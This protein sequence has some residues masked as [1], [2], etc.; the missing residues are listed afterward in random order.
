MLGYR[1]LGHRRIEIK[2]TA[3]GT[4]L[5]LGLG[6]CIAIVLLVRAAA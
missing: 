1:R 6:A 5:L 4:G 2:A 3:A